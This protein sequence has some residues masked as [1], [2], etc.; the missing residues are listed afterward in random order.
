MYENVS[1]EE[2]EALLEHTRRELKIYSLYYEK[3]K[4]DRDCYDRQVNLL[5]DDIRDL[6]K[7]L[8]KRK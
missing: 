8:E 3:L 2:L 4:V 7:E 5:L 6:Q 1:K